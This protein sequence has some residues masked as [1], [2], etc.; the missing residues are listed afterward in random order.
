MRYG[1]TKKD[2]DIGRDARST[3]GLLKDSDIREQYAEVVRENGSYII[4]D[5]GSAGRIYVNRTRVLGG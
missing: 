3:L 5:K 4:E 1:G 2:I